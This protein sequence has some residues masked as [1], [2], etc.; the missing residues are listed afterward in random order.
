MERQFFVLEGI[1]C[2]ITISG[3]AVVSDFLNGY[4]NILE[5]LIQRRAIMSEGNGP[6]MRI[7]ALYEHMAVKT[8]HFR[9]CEYPDGAKGTGGNRKNFALRHIGAENIIR[10]ALKPEKSDISRHDVAFQRAL[11]HFFRERSGH[12][13]LIFHLASVELLDGSVSAVEAHE[14]IL[15]SIVEFS[16]DISFI[17]IPWNGIVDIQQGD[18]ILADS[19]TYVFAESPVD[20]YLTGYR[21]SLGGQ[22]AVDITGDKAE[23]SLER[24]PAFS[25]D[26]GIFAAALMFIN[27]VL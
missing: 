21:N 1:L 25:G 23:L 17:Q 16:T 7:I 27:P 5:Y 15:L 3:R 19:H 18:D 9:Y 14:G 26:G 20:V 4:P 10:G 13:E 6:M 8:A 24:R 12:N 22:A 11:G 2:G